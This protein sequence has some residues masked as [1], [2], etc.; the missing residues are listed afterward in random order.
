MEFD[1]DAF[2]VDEMD[3]FQPTT[4]AARPQKPSKEKIPKP[5]IRTPQE[6]K[7]IFKRY[8]TADDGYMLS[9]QPDQIESILEYLKEYGVVVVKVLDDQQC[10][11]TIKELFEDM[12]SADHPRKVAQID[13]NDPSTWESC[14]WPSGSKFLTSTPC[15]GQKAFENRTNENIYKIFKAIY[16]EEKLWCS[17]DK[18]GIFRGTKDLPFME[19][20]EIV[21]KERSDWRYNLRNHWDLNPHVHMQEL[22]N[23]EHELYQGLVA[24]DDCPE[25]VG[26]FQAV[27]RSRNYL[28]I[29]VSERKASTMKK[30]SLPVPTDDPMSNYFQ[31]FP[32]RK[33]E[34]V[35]FNGATAHANFPNHSPNMRLFQFIRLLPASKRGYERDRFAATRV[36]KEFPDLYLSLIHI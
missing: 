10:D 14:N 24:L 34:L 12:N 32:L 23:G 11:E 31:R 2:P 6:W 21:Y 7:Q 19:D 8:P 36:K 26:G 4:K 18:W 35:I 17:I 22:A 13:R 30:V 25:E 20:G 29:W 27:P 3:I 15:F 1:D 16:N 33:G 9:F 28:P 5:T